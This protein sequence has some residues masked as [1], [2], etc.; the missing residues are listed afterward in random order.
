MRLPRAPAAGRGARRP[1]RRQ[2][3]AHRHLA[4]I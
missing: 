2:S 1:P 4:P 3:R